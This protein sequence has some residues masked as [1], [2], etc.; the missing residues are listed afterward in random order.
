[1]DDEDANA[2]DEGQLD[3]EQID[4][5]IC[6]DLSKFTIHLPYIIFWFYSWKKE[7][8][9]RIL[10][11]SESRWINPGE[12]RIIGCLQNPSKHPPQRLIHLGKSLHSTRRGLPQQQV[13][14]AGL[15]PLDHGFEAQWLSV[16][17][18]WRDEA[19]PCSNLNS[20]RKVLHGS[21]KLQR[22]LKLAWEVFK[23]ECGDFGRQPHE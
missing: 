2:M 19:I 5:K 16:L 22:F 21:R 6:G 10:Y 3:F 23:N 4:M 9:R 17:K 20:P 14:R 15:G 8:T 1:M 12:N 7:Q 11:V 13:L 18:A